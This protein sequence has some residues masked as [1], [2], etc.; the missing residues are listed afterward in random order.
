GE[1]P[2]PRGAVVPVTSVRRTIAR[3]LLDSHHAT[4]PVTLN[5]S[6]DATNLVN[7]RGQFKAARAADVLVPTYTDFLVKLTAVAL[8]RHPLLNARWEDEAVR[9]LPEI[10]IGIA[11]DTEAG[12][13]VPVLRD[14]PSLSLKQVA[15]LSHD[16]VERARA[17]R[18]GA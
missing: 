12:L 5:A 4:A 2:A 13:L 3:R 7:L 9:L 6:A 14:V 15:A 17:G 16:L 10:H 11:V 8:Q 18:L 1:P